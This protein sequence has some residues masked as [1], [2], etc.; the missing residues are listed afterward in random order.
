M[1]ILVIFIILSVRSHLKY[2]TCLLFT[3]F[4]TDKWKQV[5]INYRI[6]FVNLIGLLIIKS[7]KALVS[8]LQRSWGFLLRVNP[9]S[10][11]LLKLCTFCWNILKGTHSSKSTSSFTFRMQSC[12]YFFPQSIKCSIEYRREKR[13]RNASC[14]FIL[15]LCYLN[16]RLQ[17]ILLKFMR[18][19]VFHFGRQL[20]KLEP[21]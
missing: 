13:N 9:D 3:H 18:V 21:A 6:A 11:Y 2:Y 10:E 1:I 12:K 5:N 20:V 14:R 8:F 17:N 7:N 19:A 15:G 16:C 4:S